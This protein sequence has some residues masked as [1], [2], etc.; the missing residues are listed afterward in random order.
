M[1]RKPNV[2]TDIFISTECIGE[3]STNEGGH[4]RVA[5]EFGYNYENEKVDYWII[6]VKEP[7]WGVDGD[8]V[9][10]EEL[11]KLLAKWKQKGATHVEAQAHT[12]HREY[13]FVFY[14][15]RKSTEDEIVNFV[16]DKDVKKK[17]EKQ[18]EDLDKQREEILKQLMGK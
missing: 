6:P 8:M 2:K 5:E 16:L 13:D 12:D 18:L 1:R 4:S 15:V 11:M 17:L 14:K 10:I 7:R 3:E 9:P